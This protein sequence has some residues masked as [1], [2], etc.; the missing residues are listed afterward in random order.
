MKKDF[1]SNEVAKLLK[2]NGFNEPCMA[3]YSTQGDL[4]ECFELFGE[5]YGRMTNT[6]VIS[7]VGKHNVQPVTAPTILSAVR[8]LAENHRIFLDTNMVVSTAGEIKYDYT[9]YEGEVM[10]ENSLTNL[11]ESR[12]AAY[13]FALQHILKDLL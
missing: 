12:E 5:K 4:Y 9:I 7:V 6:V 3:V 10:V 11:F 13:D 8:W 2:A 1:V